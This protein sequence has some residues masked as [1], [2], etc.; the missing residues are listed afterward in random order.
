MSAPFAGGVAKLF[1]RHIST[2]NMLEKELQIQCQAHFRRRH[3]ER[4]KRELGT[5]CRQ[6]NHT[7][8]EGVWKRELVGMVGRREGFPNN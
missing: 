7:L 5:T 8:C 6:Q 2:A 4:E 3:T 1:Q